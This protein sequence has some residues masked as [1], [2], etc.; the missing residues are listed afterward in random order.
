[1]AQ[2]ISFK[3][4]QRDPREELLSRLQSAP[5]AHAE[6][7][8]SAYEVLQALHDRGVLDLLRGTLGAGDRIIEIVVEG[9]RS[10]EAIQAIRNA[11]LLANA[12]GA[13]DPDLLADFTRALPKALSQASREEA[14]PPGL[15]KLLGTFWNRDFRRG[16]AAVNDL[17]VAFGRNLDRKHPES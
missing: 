3:P 11:L 13:I 6:A 16:L 14:R 12:L 4:S 7:L 8:L 1:M 9:V 2:P 5:A 17:L 15:L 10:P